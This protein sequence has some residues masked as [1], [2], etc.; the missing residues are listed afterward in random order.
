MTDITT[1]KQLSVHSGN[2]GLVTIAIYLSSEESAVQFT[3]QP[4]EC[5][6]LIEALRHPCPQHVIFVAGYDVAVT[7]PYASAVPPV[8]AQAR[9]ALNG[10]EAPSS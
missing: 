2:S 5:Q 6:D 4:G 7:R 10:K 9:E 1:R 3:L 8:Y